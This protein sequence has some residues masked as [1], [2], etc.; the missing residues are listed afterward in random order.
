MLTKSDV[1]SRQA[2][3]LREVPERVFEHGNLIITMKRQRI[4]M[5]FFNSRKN[6]FESIKCFTIHR[7]FLFGCFIRL[8]K[9]SCFT[10]NIIYG[11]IF[12]DVSRDIMPLLRK[13]Q[14]EKKE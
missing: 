11:S 7:F 12:F 14:Y 9:L 3:G 10:E 6:P 8:G 5:H 4:V 2:A 1:E 13:C